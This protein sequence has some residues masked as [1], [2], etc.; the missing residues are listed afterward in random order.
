[1][2]HENPVD[3]RPLPVATRRTDDTGSGPRGTDPAALYRERRPPCRVERPHASSTHLDDRIRQAQRFLAIGVATGDPLLQTAF[4][5]AGLVARSRA[6]CLRGRSARARPVR[7]EVVQLVRASSQQPGRGKQH[8]ALL[9]CPARR[10]LRQT[11]KSAPIP[12]A[13]LPNPPGHPAV[14]RGVSDLTN[15]NRAGNGPSR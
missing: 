2:T 1:M 6:P 3:Y 5:A 10:G 14:V 15:P 4:R 12:P 13:T 8:C 11:P 7:P 9:R